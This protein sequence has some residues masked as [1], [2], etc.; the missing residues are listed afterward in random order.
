MHWRCDICDKVIYEEFRSNHLQSG[1]H[2]RLPNSIIK[3]CIFTNPEPNKID[4][5]IG[6][7]LRLHYKKYEKFQAILSVKLLRTSNQFKIIR[8]Q[9]T[10]YRGQSCLY[11]SSFLSKVKI[12]KE[13]LYSQVL[14]VRITFVSRFENI[15]FDHF[16]TT[17]KPMLEWKLVAMFKKILKL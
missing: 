10:C 5:I 11:N 8:R 7:V 9:F 2:K 14:V 12:F 16:I 1:V 6:K 17:P 4:D 13:R 3:K 15:T